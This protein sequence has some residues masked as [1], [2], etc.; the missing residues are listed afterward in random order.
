L[1]H[2]SLGGLA[3]S[4]IGQVGHV[5]RPLADE[6]NS[7]SAAELGIYTNTAREFPQNPINSAALPLKNKGFFQ[8]ARSL[9]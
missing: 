7:Q 9:Q 1:I 4:A 5:R 3:L 6:L 2:E 8:L